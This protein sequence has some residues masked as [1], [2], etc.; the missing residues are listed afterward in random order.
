M[1]NQ[2]SGGIVRELMLSNPDV[3]TKYLYGVEGESNTYEL[4]GLVNKADPAVNGNFQLMV[5]KQ[6]VAGK[7]ETTVSND[8]ALDVSEFEFVMACAASLKDTV[9]VF[10]NTNGV[11]YS[12]TVAIVDT[13]SLDATKSR[14]VL[15]LASG[16]GFVRQ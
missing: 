15:K 6:L 5:E 16:Q 9:A 14:F 13:P 10:T 1:A 8:E 11:R 12:G 3:G 4:G 7:M 2:I